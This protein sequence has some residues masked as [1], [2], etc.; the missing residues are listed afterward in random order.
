MLRTD[1][2]VVIGANPVVSH[3]SVLTVRVSRTTCTR[4]NAAG[5][6]LVIDPAAPNR[7]TIRMVGIIARRRRIPLAVPW[8]QV[9]F[10]EQ[11]RGPGRRRARQADGLDW[12]EAL[13][14]PYPQNRPWRTGI[15]PRR[16]G[17]LARD[18]VRTRRA[19]VYGRFGTS[20]RAATAR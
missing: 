12:L 8:P 9:M 10:D 3:G 15:D 7:G 2:L 16:S 5:R 4:S 11:P 6:V 17:G 18:L 1:L 14:R 20:A 19:A 13:C